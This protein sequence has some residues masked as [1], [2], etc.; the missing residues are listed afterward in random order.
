MRCPKCKAE[1]EEDAVFCTNCGIEIES[2]IK[3]SPDYQEKPKKNLVSLPAEQENFEKQEKAKDFQKFKK[4]EEIESTEQLEIF[5][6]PKGLEQSKNF[7]QSEPIKSKNIEKSE[8][9]KSNI[10]DM[11]EPNP[12]ESDNIQKAKLKEPRVFKKSKPEKP[13]S[14]SFAETFYQQKERFNIKDFF[15]KHFKVIIGTVFILAA[16]IFTARFIYSVFF[17]PIDSIIAVCDE[18]N[19]EHTIY[20]N[21]KKVGTVSGTAQIYNNMD[22]SAFY[23]IDREATAWYIKGEKLVDIMEDCKQIVIANH[24]KT[25]LLIDSND[26]LFRY[27]GSKLEK[28][29]EE[30]VYNI[31][32]SGNGDY[33]SYTVSNGNEYN[34]YIGKEPD[35]EEKVENIKIFAI[36]EKGEYFYG[37][38]RKN[39]LQCINRKGNAV[40]VANDVSVNSA[41]SIMLN[42]NG[43]EIMFV[44]DDTTYIFIKGK[45]KKKVADYVIS[46]VYGK[47]TGNDFSY[48]TDLNCIFY[49][50]DTFKKS[51]GYESNGRNKTVCLISGSYTAKEI[52]KNVSEFYGTD[53]K[54]SKIYYKKVGTIYSAEAEEDAKEKRLTKETDK[55]I[56]EYFSK[57]SAD[58][59]FVTQD[60]KIGCV[61]ENGE[62]EYADIEIDKDTCQVICKTKDS[63]YIQSNNKF[64]YVNGKKTKELK[65][66]KGICYDELSDKIYAYT[67]EQVYEVKNGNMKKLKE[68]FN[69]IIY[70]YLTI[71]R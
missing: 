42:E 8:P 49:P 4:S 52:V 41:T 53:K 10:A 55:V 23:I 71:Y 51:V 1:L 21:S 18:D 63:L 66:V 9:E 45:T 40:D 68:D 35:K 27:N 12:K 61:K 26:C 31:A 56:R 3:W 30:E 28:I 48:M 25:A 5:E 65:N 67:R 57:N 6:Q 19:N 60:S 69:K 36:S 62:T 16:V 20:L 34:S 64:F 50:M 2:Y 15:K 13:K 43:T 70:V 59:Y 22:R 11:E 17:G 32:V 54:A 37:L 39:H 33:Y 46:S 58:I 29:T 24:D 38:G 44:V 47:E 14:P 7:E